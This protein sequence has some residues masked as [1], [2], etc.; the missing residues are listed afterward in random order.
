M[1]LSFEHYTYHTPVASRSSVLIIPQYMCEEFLAETKNKHCTNP[2]ITDPQTVRIIKDYYERI[3]DENTNKLE[4]IGLIYATLGLVL[5]HVFLENIGESRDASLSSRLLF[6]I[7]EHYK[8][9]SRRRWWLLTSVI[10][11]AICPAISNPASV[12]I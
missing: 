4:R 11:R 12:S 6:Y 1:A 7:N 2:F 8:T 5:K 3:R 9:A 10:P